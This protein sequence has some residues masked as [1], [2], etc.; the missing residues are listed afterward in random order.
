MKKDDKTWFTAITDARPN[1]IRLR[2][3]RIDELM[4][5]NAY[6]Q[7]VFLAFTGRL[8]NE[9]EGR[10][11]DAILVSSID[12]G[13]TPPSTLVARTVAGCD[14]PLTSAL[15]AGILSIGKA[16]GGAVEGCMELIGE[17][18]A[19]ADKEGVSIEEA[20]ERIVAEAEA[21]GRRLPGLGHRYHTADP[22]SARLFELAEECKFSG[23]HIQALKAIETAFAKSKGKK[24]PINIDGAIAACL[25]EMGF[26]S[27]AGNGFFII[28]RTTGL[29]NHILEE[30][31]RQ[32]KMRKIFPDSAVYDGEG[33]KRL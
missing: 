6:S 5:R 2:G 21:C 31:A 19:M 3:Y 27:S 28:A 29:I 11:V 25:C 30:W 24:I 15:A 14:A 8:P 16:H 12:H 7:A 10:L 32:P 9:E 33:D 1:S 13:A 23:R 20:G 18:V 26:P 4:G 17:T 22:R